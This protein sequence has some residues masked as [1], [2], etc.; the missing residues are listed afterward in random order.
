LLDLGLWH[1]YQPRNEVRLVTG[2]ATGIVLAT[3]VCFLLATTL[4]RA[5]HANRRVVSG[6]G[7][8]VVLA[9]LH[10]PLALLLV[11]RP[12]VLYAPI[13]LGLV[14]SAVAVVS[15]LALVVL[16]ILRRRENT[17]VRAAQ[18]DQVGATALMAGVAVMALIAGG[19]F[20]LEA[21]AGVQPMP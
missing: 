15:S 5:G 2:L 19:R 21:V 16:T 17:Y 11:A 18:L 6:I 1:A 13:A 4:W 9:A 20:W 10:V 7:E 14:L 12:Y 8:V 3:V